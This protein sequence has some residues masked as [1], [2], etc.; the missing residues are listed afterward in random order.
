MNE[1]KLDPIISI[2]TLAEKVGLSVS[3]IRKYEEEGLIIS[4]RAES[5]HRLF[6]YEDIDRINTIQ[7]LIKDIGLNFEG[8]RRMQALLPCWDILPC[9]PN[10]RD[11]CPALR[12]RSKSC[13]MLKYSPCTSQGN[14]CRE[15]T[16]YRIGTLY[17]EEIKLFLHNPS[18]TFAPD[19][20]LK[21]HLN[22]NRHKRKEE[23]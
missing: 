6:C 17:L 9:N 3:A 20:A 12:E 11:N 22:N 21:Q 4:F 7:Y 1:A 15:C 8:I 16:V 14:I 10:E 13:W 19:V 23:K 2:G 18:G 5:G